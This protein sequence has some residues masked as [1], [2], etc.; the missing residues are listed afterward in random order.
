MTRPLGADPPDPF[1]AGEPAA[2][3]SSEGTTG[4][5][6]R[7]SLW[8]SGGQG[9]TL[10]AALT[11]TPFVIRMLG[12]E[13]YG[14]LALMNV[15]TAC[16]AFSDLGMGIAST[17]FG[18]EAHARGDDDGEA[19]AIWAG[20]LLGALPATL[21]ATALAAG[22]SPLL[23]ALHVPAHLQD[24]ATIALR[25]AAIGIVARVVT[26]VFNTPQL[27]RLR[28]RLHA[29]VTTAGSVLQIAGIP[30]ALSLGAGLVGAGAVIAGVGI[31]TAVCQTLIA[32]RILPRLARPRFERRLFGRLARFGGAIV[33][34]SFTGLLLTN[35]EKLF[36][37]RLV[38]VE[39]L[40]YYT[41]A[42]SL[43]NLLIIPAAA[44][45]HAM[46]PTFTRYQANGQWEDLAR[47]YGELLRGVLLIMP[48]IALALFAG[49]RPFFT[50]WAGP[51]FGMTSTPLFF[52]MIV[53]VF[54]MVSAYVPACLLVAVD[55]ADFGARYNLLEL[56]PYLLLALL[57][58]ARWGGAG[59]AAAWSL[60][61][62]AALPVFLLAARRSLGLRHATPPPLGAD[63]FTALAV[64]VLPSIAAALLGI[65]WP[66]LPLAAV[67]SSAVYLWI[68]FARLLDEGE[69]GWV[70][71]KLLVKWPGGAA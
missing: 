59:A 70:R 9:V 42:F 43:A 20:L 48:L 23:R 26:G 50:L 47:I 46:L 64:L 28:M 56:I 14:V 69:R 10:L 41:V 17:R 55:R 57:L 33:V 62:V 36:L 32:R 13:Q 54:T 35:G 29:A 7:G 39:A 16:L 4:Q 19:A 37:T 3:L 18:A 22:A 31:V 67:T 44:L 40:A 24:E 66:L 8:Y 58:T 53:G 34:S 2:A 49:A 63:Y 25:L 51:R 45:Y 5:V 71:S 68:V 11:A 61:S 30:V 65:S 15:L 21:A 27:V 52:V 60:R 12:P 6:V 38:S 1:S